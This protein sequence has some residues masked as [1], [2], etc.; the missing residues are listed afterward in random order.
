MERGQVSN[1]DVANAEVQSLHTEALTCHYLS[2]AGKITE[3]GK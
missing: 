1:L 2:F 3:P